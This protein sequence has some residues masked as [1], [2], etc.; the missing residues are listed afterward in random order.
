MKLLCSALLFLFCL[1]VLP[2][3]A[4]AQAGAS[5]TSSVSGQGTHRTTQYT[6]PPDKLAKAKALY[7]LRGKLRLINTFYG[8]LILWALLQFGISAR[9]RD[10]AELVGSN[11]FAQAVVWVLLFLFVTTL[12]GLP[13]DMYQHSIS[14]A[15]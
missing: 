9:F 2:N 10:V 15:Y 1:V 4:Q 3:Q 14:R 5:S 8:L 12:L 11:R 6:L 7:D 13:L